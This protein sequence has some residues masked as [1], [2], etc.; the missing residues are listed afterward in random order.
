MALAPWHTLH[1]ATSDQLLQ[2]N[3]E[4]C[5]P[6]RKEGHLDEHSIKE[7]RVGWLEGFLCRERKL[8]TLKPVKYLTLLLLHFAIAENSSDYRYGYYR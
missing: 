5:S 2:R 1:F 3:S 6:K 8:P 7:N 4:E